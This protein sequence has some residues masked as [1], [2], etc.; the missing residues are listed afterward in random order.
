MMILAS[1][2]PRRQELLGMITTDFTV[3]VS[4][5][6]ESGITAETPA[7]LAEK[8]ATAKCLAVAADEPDTLVL[9]CD[10]VVEYEG[11]VFGKPRDKEDAR[12][13]LE[14]LSGAEHLVHTGICL[15][16]GGAVK[17]TVATSR[18]HFLPIEP[19]DLTGYLDTK[20]PYDKAGAYAIQGHAGL[21][22]DSIQGTYFN[23][24]GLPVCQVAQL[25]KEF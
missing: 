11:Q 13:M 6:D 23:I 14:A 9:G 25:M 10:T 24:M 20:E 8:L 2:S 12:R 3:K 5:V 19:S 4:D 18:V 17:S 16:K 7:L 15:A 21:W 22:C 1:G